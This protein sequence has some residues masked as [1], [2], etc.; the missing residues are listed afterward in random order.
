MLRTFAIRSVQQ[1]YNRFLIDRGRLER[2]RSDK[3]YDGNVEDSFRLVPGFESMPCRI[4]TGQAKQEA[5]VRVYAQ[6]DAPIDKVR[7]AF[8]H[9]A[10]LQ[11]GDR[12]TV[13]DR[14]YQIEELTDDLSDLIGKSALMARVRD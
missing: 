8:R 9:D 2:R 12:I 4:I 13:G 3:T 11:I 10:P 5:I 14:A 1:E 6:T 7:G